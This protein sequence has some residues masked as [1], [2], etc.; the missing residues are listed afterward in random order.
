MEEKLIAENRL[1]ERGYTGLNM[2]S[3]QVLEDFLTEMRGSQAY[4]RFNEMR[5]NSPVVGAMLVAVEQAIRGV[6]WQFTSEAG[7]EDGRL[8]FLQENLDSMSHNLNDHVTEALTFLPF[9][10][11]VFEI[12]YQ[13]AESGQIYWRK[14]AIRGQDTIYQ[15]LTDDTGGLAGVRQSG[16]P[17]YK[18][19]D[20]PIEKLVLY[21]TRIEKN[22]PE[23][24]SILRTA[25]IPYYYLKNLM[26]VEAIGFER[27]LSGY[28]VIKLPPGAN[29]DT[30]DTNSDASKADKMVRN[31]RMDEQAGVVLPSEWDFQFAD[32]G[33]KSGFQYIGEAIKRYESR[34]LMSAMAQFLML[35]QDNV[36]SFA[37]SS[38]QTDFFTMS[39]NATA[40]IIAETITKYAVPRLL[41]MNGMDADG[42]RL[43]HSPAG[44]IDI[45]LIADFL[46]KVGAMITWLPQDEVWLRSVARL[47]EADEEE[48]EAERERKEQQAMQIQAAF[49]KPGQQ[50][51][52]DK[53][54]NKP[55]GAT[56]YATGRAP[57]DDER[58]RWE[59]RL[60]R[61]V[62]TYWAKAKKR[63][64]K[65]ARGLR[66]Q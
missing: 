61:L 54:G 25:W 15:W 7:E 60:E 16:P 28:P 12:V 35:G 51:E 21:R 34:I 41:A 37:L 47:P 40:D 62:K 58:R 30:S 43:E 10:Y 38:D 50:G 14:F 31:I 59:G 22:N 63:V 49:N 19:V 13:R 39:V 64:L 45:T 4:K 56:Q 27:G 18:L 24:R 20:I 36:G 32:S 11:S 66:A 52:D 26:Q 55:F 42:I 48:L 2:F 3:G 44:D 33:D 6:D 9:G 1:G 57:D 46:Q 8:E 5:L 53:G 17:S 65:G 29:T 23:G